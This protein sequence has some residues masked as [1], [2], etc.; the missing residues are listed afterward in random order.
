MKKLEKFKQSSFLRVFN[1][2]KKNPNIYLYTLVLDFIF[3]AVIMFIG[4]YF[5]SL[6]PS[7][8]Q[9]LTELFKTQTRMLVFV[10]IY[11]VVY[12][13]FITFIYSLLKLKILN[14]ITNLYEK[15]KF[16]LK[17]LGKFYLLNLSIL[18]LFVFTALILLGILTLLIQK[19][20]LAPITLILLIPFLFFLYSIINISHTFFI[21]K[22]EKPL[23]SSF[24]ILFTK[25]NKY[26]MFIVWNIALILI[27]LI[28]YNIIHLLLKFTI[29]TNQEILAAYGGIY[30]KTLNIVSLIAVFLL[31]AFNRI[32]FYELGKNVLS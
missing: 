3:L 1:I 28:F 31:I 27:Y 23:K 22:K 15:R 9:Q 16:T 6:I 8:P 24:K 20:A 32:Y 18:A 5:G 30:L 26:G 7:D 25:I 21:N 29:F 10:L 11:P 12:Y 4:K 2:I 14:F 17:R 19:E 13:A